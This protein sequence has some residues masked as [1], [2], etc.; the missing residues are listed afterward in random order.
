MFNPINLSSSN[1][2]DYSN[3]GSSDDDFSDD[4]N[5]QP[6]SGNDWE[7]REI[8]L[9]NEV[10]SLVPS[11]IM[12]HLTLI[13]DII[14]VSDRTVDQVFRKIESSVEE[15]EFIYKIIEF[16]LNIRPL[17]AEQLLSLLQMLAAEHGYD[18]ADV[19]D[20]RVHSLLGKY[21]IIS[22]ENT[23][24]VMRG[25]DINAPQVDV[26]D[27]IFKDDLDSFLDVVSKLDFNPKS[28]VKVD[29]NSPIKL[30]MNGMGGDTFSFLQVITFYGATKIF[31]NAILNNQFPIN[32]VAEFV[33]AGG[34]TEI[35]H[36]L[37]Q[38][39]VSFAN[40][41]EVSIRYHRNDIS[42]W[43][44]LHN[45]CNENSFISSCSCY[46][47]RALIYSL[48]NGFRINDALLTATE[49]C[50]IKIVKYLVDEFHF[51]VNEEGLY[52]P[53]ERKQNYSAFRGNAMMIEP[54]M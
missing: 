2:S 53:E 17:Y 4:E 49:Q 3:S 46:N 19:V 5:V 22:K 11:F 35:I 18:R 44:I 6:Q 52:K 14:N 42:D 20:K 34:N 16:A 31:K 25:I 45:K 10:D 33:I 40:C 12:K 36:I 48:M 37:E 50:N 23:L 1:S 38:R 7:K 9:I 54:E 15:I 39:K 24:S 41:L 13:N 21:G 32:E 47:Y 8:K 30:V 43:I 28:T 51:N 29:R 26:E 27:I